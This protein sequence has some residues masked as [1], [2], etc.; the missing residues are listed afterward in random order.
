MAPLSITSGRIRLEC[1]ELAGHPGRCRLLER[2]LSATQ[3]IRE[4][5]ANHRTGRLLLL[6][7]ESVHTREQAMAVAREALRVVKDAPEGVVAA[8]GNETP[9]RRDQLISGDLFW[10]VALHLLVPAPLDFLLP[11]AAAFRK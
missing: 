4:A 8:A 3:G 7:D 2:G 1:G 6:F 9:S 10:D 11:A 5:S